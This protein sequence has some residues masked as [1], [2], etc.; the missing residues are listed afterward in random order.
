MILYS[1]LRWLR[2]AWPFSLKRFHVLG[3][4]SALGK[5][6]LVLADIALR[7]GIERTAHVAGDPYTTAVN[8]GRQDLAREILALAG[9][10]P[11]DVMEMI[12]RKPVEDRT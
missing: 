12:E 7:G 11:S 8:I 10:V 5:M 2:Q 1:H 9:C 6:R 4:Y 3:E